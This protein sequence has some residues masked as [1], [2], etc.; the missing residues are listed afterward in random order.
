MDHYKDKTIKLRL[1]MS[2]NYFR[3]WKNYLETT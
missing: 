1:K 2:N 3:L